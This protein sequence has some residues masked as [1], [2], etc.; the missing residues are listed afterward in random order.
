[1]RIVPPS[2]AELP[3]MAGRLV[4]GF[5]ISQDRGILSLDALAPGTYT[6]TL[7]GSSIVRATRLVLE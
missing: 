4:R 3:D 5:I 6:V 2:R 7:S 1:M